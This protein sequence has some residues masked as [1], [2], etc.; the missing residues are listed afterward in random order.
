MLSRR[1]LALVRR[2]M[3][4]NTCVICN[5]HVTTRWKLLAHRKHAHNADL[6]K[7][8]FCQNEYLTNNGRD[9]HEA[10]HHGYK[11]ICMSPISADSSCYNSVIANLTPYRYP[12][13]DGPN[14]Q[15]SVSVVLARTCR[16]CYT[17]YLD[18]DARLKHE[19]EMHSETAYKYVL[20][21]VHSKLC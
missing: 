2:R 6:L 1:L 7:C 20:M 21:D 19:K 17:C 8:R 18:S 10:K 12:E 4:R 9:L 14:M 11:T 13:T 15:N 16:F 3:V 5:L